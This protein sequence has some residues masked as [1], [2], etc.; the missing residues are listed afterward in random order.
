LQCGLMFEAQ[1][2]EELARSY[3]DKCLAFTAI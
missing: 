3:F 2:K 1:N